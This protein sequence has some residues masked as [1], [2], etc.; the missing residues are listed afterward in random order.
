MEVLD[1]LKRRNKIFA[2]QWKWKINT[3]TIEWSIGNCY[4]FSLTPFTALNIIYRP[5][6]FNSGH[7]L[8]EIKLVLL[9]IDPRVCLM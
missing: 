3:G 1:M 4:Y 8:N 9:S 5:T 2:N 7:F 6:S